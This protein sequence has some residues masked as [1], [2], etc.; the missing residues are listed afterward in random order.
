MRRD[1]RKC[2]GCGALHCWNVE[3]VLEN[4]G[5]LCMRQER[6]HMHVDF[7]NGELM[8]VGF[9][10]NFATRKEWNEL[11]VP[12]ACDRLESYLLE[13]WNNNEEKS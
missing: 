6:V 1:F 10:D 3:G 5:Y 12:S 7:V 8:L 2:K 11:D 13:E 4:A 9:K